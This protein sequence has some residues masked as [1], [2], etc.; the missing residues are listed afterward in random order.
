LSFARPSDEQRRFVLSSRLE[1]IGLSPQHVDALVAATGAQR[2]GRDFGFTFSDLTQRL[3][4]GIVLDAYPS[5]AIDGARA[6]QIARAMAPT[7][8]FRDGGAA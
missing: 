8:P 3:L 2:G 4:P 7:P 5:K 1:P 6:V